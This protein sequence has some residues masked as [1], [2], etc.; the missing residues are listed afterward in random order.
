M[1]TTKAIGLFFAGLDCEMDSHKPSPRTL[2]KL[3][4]ARC[5]ARSPSSASRCALPVRVQA[6]DPEALEKEVKD[7]WKTNFKSIKHF[8]DGDEDLPAPLRVAEQLKEQMDEFQTKLPLISWLCNPGMRERHWTEILK[9][10]GYPFKPTET[11]TLSSML[12]MGLEVH[13]EKLEEIA[14]GASKE[15][16]LEKALDKMLAEWTPQELTVLDYRDTGTCI[17]DGVDDIQTL[18]DDHVVKSQTMQGSPF[19]KPFEE[20]AKKWGN[21]LVLIQDLIDIWLKVQAVWQYL[22]PIFGSED[23]MR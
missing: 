19:I 16:S 23:I 2:M 20:R 12:T 4:P 9:V 17:I 11:T 15:F 14:G 21:K 1:D 3:S 13:L 5:P 7:M 22:E 10:L 8:A 6:L 18:L